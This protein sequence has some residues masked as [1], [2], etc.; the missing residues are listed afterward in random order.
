MRQRQVDSRL[1]TVLPGGSGCCGIEGAPLNPRVANTLPTVGTESATPVGFALLKT[2]AE[3]HG[4]HIPEDVS[5]RVTF[6]LPATIGATQKKREART[7]LTGWRARSAPSIKQRIRQQHFL[8]KVKKRKGPGSASGP[9]LVESQ[10]G[11]TSVSGAGPVAGA[12]G[13]CSLRSSL[14]TTSARMDHDVI[15]VVFDFFP[16]P[17]GCS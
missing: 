14:R 3:N 13:Y 2:R 12:S 17:L 9:N 4:A 11:A 1:I 6:L 5:E 7:S 16:L 15:F 8:S 10:N